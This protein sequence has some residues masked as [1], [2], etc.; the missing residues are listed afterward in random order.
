MPVTKK[1]VPRRGTAFLVPVTGFE[2]VR[3]YGQ[4]ILSPV[5]LPFHHTGPRHT[6]CLDY[7]KGGVLSN[8]N[9]DPGRKKAKK[10]KGCICKVSVLGV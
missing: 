6:A 10:W 5:C 3:P 7:T 9:P 8:R 2:P 4:G 1:A